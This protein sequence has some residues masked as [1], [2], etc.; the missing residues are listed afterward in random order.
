MN[1][2]NLVCLLNDTY[3]NNDNTE[4]DVENYKTFVIEIRHKTSVYTVP[5][6]HNDYRAATTVRS[7]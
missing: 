4:L 1:K 5:D 6:G 3:Y 2:N 7:E